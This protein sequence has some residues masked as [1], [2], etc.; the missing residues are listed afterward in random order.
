MLTPTE[1]FFWGCLLLLQKSGKY[2]IGDITEM[3]LWLE[4]FQAQD[5][6]YPCKNP[7][8]WLIWSSISSIIFK[9]SKFL[10]KYWSFIGLQME[11]E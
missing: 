5:F 4:G 7:G 2:N 6:H 11:L 10:G 1:W 8:F 9:V 3:D